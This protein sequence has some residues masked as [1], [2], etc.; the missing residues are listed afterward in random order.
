[1]HLIYI[2]DSG[3]EDFC[4]FSA[5]AIPGNKWKSDFEK[6]REFRRSLRK[7]HGIYVYKE[8]HAWKF[9]SGRG[10]ISERVVTK[11]HRCQI[12]K[13]SLE[14][15]TRLDGAR[16]FNAVFEKGQDVMAFERLVNRINRTLEAWDSY[17]LLICDEG[18]ESTYTRL[19]R[20]M[21]KFNPI[22]SQFGVW[23]DTGGMRK[24]IPIDRIIEDP[25]FKES[26]K[27]YFI[28][29]VDFAAY[30]LLCGES[31]KH[32]RKRHGLN[33]AFGLLVPILVTEATR[34]DSEGII[35]PSYGK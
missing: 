18:K 20:R 22:P 7:R 15:L 29:L 33:E 10:D 14:L 28:Q 6:V 11:F 16:L 8:L 35:R 1:L 25:W 31:P 19:V 27:S 3:D 4:I 23:Q 34:Y 30:A 9:V 21:G 5:L 13:E 24:N 12:F 2:D 17:G 26:S 32:S